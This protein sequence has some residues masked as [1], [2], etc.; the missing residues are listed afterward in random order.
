MSADYDFIGFTYDGK[1]SI[2]DLKIYRTSDGSRYQDQLTANMTD[3]TAEVPGS[4]GI[5]YFGTKFKD[6]TFN[7][8][9]AF[10]DLE[11]ADLQRL[12]QTFSGDGIHDLVFD[13]QPY[14]AWSAK[15]T[16]TPSL[17]F[18]CF[19]KDNIRK[20]KGEGTVVFTCYYPYAHTPNKLWVYEN[21]IWSYLERDGRNLYNYS[22]SAYPTKSEWNQDGLL[23]YYNTPDIS[24]RT[25]QF[26]YGDLP[27]HFEYTLKGINP[28]SEAH[29]R[30]STIE[31]FQYD[32]NTQ[33]RGQIVCKL[34]FETIYLKKEQLIVWNSKTGLL[35]KV[36]N[37]IK[38]IIPYEVNIGSGNF[39]LQAQNSYE[40]SY[41]GHDDG[42]GLTVD[43][44]IKFNY[45][46][47]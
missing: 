14:K 43:R 26:I 34:D 28:S 33:T 7:I 5:Y 45:E 21:D 29:M 19:N 22:D 41:L 40:F 15:V 36:I 1:H 8:Q 3:I 4:N 31:L 18:V 37:G 16:G 35:Y 44:S 25:L 12:K 46:F 47:Y 24:N 32:Q 23:P 42:T 13:E 10:D 39:K 9:F 2:R 20:Y 6:R 30:I 17:K 38:T 27:I 11:E